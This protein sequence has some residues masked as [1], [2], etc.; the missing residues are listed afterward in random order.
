MPTT[1]K[2]IGVIGRITNPGVKETLKIL[3]DYLHHLGKKTRVDAETAAFLKDPSLSTIP[4]EQLGKHCDL[5]IV[6]G[7][8]GS[9]LNAAHTLVHDNVPVLGINRGSLG[10]L[11]DIHPTELIKIKA[12]LEGNF[13]LEKRFLLTATIEL[14]GQLLSSSSDPRLALNEFALIPDA[15]PHMMEF[16][17]YINNQFVSSQRSDGIIIAT[18]T[19]STAYALSAGGPILHPDL[20][21]VVLVPMFPHTLSVRPIVLN[22]NQELRIIVTPNNTTSPRLACD[23]QTYISIPFGSHINI[24]KNAQQLHLV[25][26][27]DYDYY[28]TLRSKLHWGHK[29]QYTE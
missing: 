16:E 2:T 24:K 20:D 19:G 6:V 4:R 11:T 10:F 14:H 21:A 17:I 13:I 5:V 18:P 15:T 27:Q 3:I 1:M 29:L 8:D 23:G 9:L 7:G 25:H 28:E 26:P 22:G 12:I